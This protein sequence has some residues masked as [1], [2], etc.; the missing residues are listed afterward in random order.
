MSDV[1]RMATPSVSPPEVAVASLGREN[2]ASLMAALARL[3]A[4]ATATD[5]PDAIL[6]AAYAVLPGVGS[7]G[8]VS[9]RLRASGMDA[10]FSRRVRA[11]WPT[12]GICLGMQL[13]FEGSEESPGAPGMGVVAGTL[14]RFEGVAVPQF[15]WNRVSGGCPSAGGGLWAYFANSY[16]AVS[17]P[18]G[19]SASWAYHGGPFIAALERGSTLLCQFHPELSGSGGQALLAR[20]L[21][22]APPSAGAESGQADAC[23]AAAGPAPRVIPC[24][25]VSGGR[26]VKGTRFLSLADAGRPEELA[27]RYSA[28]GADELAVLDIGAGIGRRE[29][30]RDVLRAVRAAVNLPV[31][32]GGGI[33]SLADAEALFAAGADKVSVNS[34]AFRDP[35]LVSAIAREFGS[36]ACVVAVDAARGA[37]GAARVVLDAGRT[38]TDT[39]AA[40]WIRRAAGL[41][42]GEFL[43]TSRDRD[44]TRDGYDLP[45]LME[46]RKA[47]GSVPLVA[48][49]GAGSAGHLLAGLRAGAD[50]VLLAGMLHDRSYGIGELKRYLAAA[51]ERMRV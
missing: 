10:A 8:A 9:E 1:P 31:C 28:D 20:W 16:R 46:A 38:M 48:S 50:A 27:A 14:G 34:R 2:V 29:H 19:W 40:D 3:G 21:G 23:A 18:L 44:G 35:G 25:D 42:A 6:N 30:D 7:F 43:L 45:L 47:A 33:R 26:V 37:D 17:A 36:Q 32:A 4:R 41:G 39:P 15:G 22:L 5:R 12:M 13:F 11:D 24:L 51:G 49:G